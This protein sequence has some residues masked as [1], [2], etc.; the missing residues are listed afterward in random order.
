MTKNTVQL[1]ALA[2]PK[3][4]ITLKNKATGTKLVQT[5][6][7]DSTISTYHMLHQYDCQ[8]EPESLK[9]VDYEFQG[10][11]VSGFI[12]T[13]SVSRPQQSIFVN[14]R[15]VED[16]K[17]NTF[18]RDLVS[19]STL[20]INAGEGVL[21][22]IFITCK[23]KLVD[24]CL[25][26]NQFLEF[27]NQDDVLNLLYNGIY[28][29]LETHSL[30]PAE[31]VE[32]V[33]LNETTE[34][35]NLKDLLL[36]VSPVYN[37][38]SDKVAR[39]KNRSPKPI[40]SPEQAIKQPE[41]S[42]VPEQ[43]T[44]AK[45]TTPSL[46]V[47][48]NKKRKLHRSCKKTNKRKSVSPQFDH[49]RLKV[50]VS[51]HKPPLYFKTPS[52]HYRSKIMRDLERAPFLPRLSSSPDSPLDLSLLKNSTPVHNKSWI[53][54]D[55]DISP[56]FNAAKASC[57]KRKLDSCSPTESGYL[58]Y[59]SSFKTS[60]Q[61][62]TSATTFGM[63]PGIDD[64]NQ[65]YVTKIQ[66]ERVRK[67]KK[68]EPAP[69]YQP[70]MIF[71][72]QTPACFYN[73]FSHINKSTKKDEQPNKPAATKFKLNQQDM[74]TKE[75]M[76]LKNTN[77]WVF[78]SPYL[79]FQPVQ[80]MYVT[81][82]PYFSERDKISVA[83]RVALSKPSVSDDE[84]NVVSP[85]CKLQTPN[86]ENYTA[87]PY[88]K[89][90]V[91]NITNQMNHSR[92]FKPMLQL[93]NVTES[94]YF[95]PVTPTL[96]SVVRHVKRESTFS[97]STDQSHISPSYINTTCEKENMVMGDSVQSP[98]FKPKGCDVSTQY[99][100][101]GM[102]VSG[103]ISESPS[104]IIIPSPTKAF[105]NEVQAK[106]LNFSYSCSSVLDDSP[107]TTDPFTQ[108]TPQTAQH[109]DLK[110]SGF[111]EFDTPTPIRQMIS[112]ENRETSFQNAD[113]IVRRLSFSPDAHLI[114]SQTVGAPK[115]IQALSQEVNRFDPALGCCVAPYVI[116]K[117]PQYSTV[118][119]LTTAEHIISDNTPFKKDERG[120]SKPCSN[121][122]FDA[123][124]W[125][126]PT[127]QT[128]GEGYVNVRN[129]APV[130]LKLLIDGYKFDSSMFNEIVVLDQIDEKFIAVIVN[131]SLLVIVDQHAAHERVRLECFLRELREDAT[132]PLNSKT[133]K[134]SIFVEKPR[135]EL[136]FISNI[137][138]KLSFLGFNV[139]VSPPHCIINT[140][141]LVCTNESGLNIMTEQ[142]L[143]IFEDCVE[144]TRTSNGANVTMPWKLTDFLHSKS[145]HGAIRF[146][147]KLGKAQCEKL[148][149]QLG[150]CELPF[151]CAHGRPSWA[152]IISLD[153]GQV[154]E[155]E[156]NFMKL[157]SYFM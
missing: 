79:Q 72:L 62:A 122:T 37:I 124:K 99:T 4:A 57:N 148:V 68:V 151:Q 129:R 157:R 12:S 134:H 133:L 91:S 67:R 65:C 155:K 40:M 141:P 66:E 105:S 130:K 71:T 125:K 75:E 114:S 117:A 32:E 90:Q 127:F 69:T 59:K 94:P 11:T 13:V 6:S 17:I 144:Q 42:A 81:E 101:E 20:E 84:T 14:R 118:Q 61:S 15:F 29:F 123:R 142:L 21:F 48:P 24:M 77:K 82:S 145:C 55:L 7:V 108:D 76:Q 106:Y 31:C 112:Q 128:L 95:K 39:G 126:N 56:I 147:D 104:V 46:R 58:S 18:I 88:F 149:E 22:V 53:P 49:K 1:I 119:P 26:S 103:H 43:P 47:S 63:N 110:S 96:S 25:D 89:P 50:S 36:K 35:G 150:H 107:I 78:S 121:Y 83:L 85:Y 154:V 52:N 10:Y 132:Q 116:P 135:P 51:P 115:V 3:V 156:L 140:A 143:E 139:S 111:D 136:D 137:I 146:G 73:R 64:L 38:K 5:H 27:H 41:Q 131:G 16:K 93:P 102:D 44:L 34:C 70:D 8:V 97:Q 100:P 2:N 92:F 28:S 87:S 86:V 152:P 60:L 138:N 19:A 153:Q 23:P 120:L 9:P 98:Y 54:P 45:P 80:K 30:L 109:N 33:M 113:K 74:L